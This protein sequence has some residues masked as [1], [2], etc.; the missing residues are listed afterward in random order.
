MVGLVLRAQSPPRIAVTIVDLGSASIHEAPLSQPQ[1]SIP[2]EN[3]G[4]N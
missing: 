4:R 1:G 3:T 2:L